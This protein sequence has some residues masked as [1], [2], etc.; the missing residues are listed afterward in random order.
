MSITAKQ[1]S[2][3][4][5]K[6]K[7]LDTIIRDQLIIIDDSLQRADR[8]WGRNVIA[9]TLPT[10]FSLPGLK[11]KD[12]QRIIYAT[13][14]KNLFSRGFN[15]RILLEAERTTLF[16]EWVT[17]LNSEEIDTMNNLIRR[18]RIAPGEVEGFLTRDRENSTQ[19]K[20]PHPTIP[21]DA[22]YLPWNDESSYQ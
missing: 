3:S 9:Q 1:L 8:T 10:N 11:K 22:P 5:A 13:I 20:P 14:I 4:G 21:Q 7:D 15:V 2:K 6:G 18:V 17:G 12:A 16:L 19:A